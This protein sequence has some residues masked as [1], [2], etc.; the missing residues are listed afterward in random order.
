MP[1]GW[2]MMNA[3]PNAPSAIMLPRD[4]AVLRCAVPCRFDPAALESL[5]ASQTTL[6]VEATICRTLEGIAARLDALQVARQRGA[7]SEML[8]PARRIAKISEGLGLIDVALAAAHVST[9]AQTTSMVAVAATLARLERCFDV[10][11]SV[12]WDHCAFQ[13][14]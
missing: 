2:W 3:P 10:A 13:Q 5:F 11:I 14:P 12:V 8:M 4:V 9:A 7:L 6:A 1:Y